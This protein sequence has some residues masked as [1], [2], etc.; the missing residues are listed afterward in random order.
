MTSL[1][2]H[3]DGVAPAPEYA[4]LEEQARAAE[5][6]ETPPWPARAILDVE[7]LT[8]RV[9]DPCCGTGVLTLA[10]RQAGYEVYASDLHDWGF[11][12]ADATGEDFLSWEPAGKGEIVN[13]ATVFMNPPFSRATEFVDQAIRLGARKLLC[14]QR[15]AWRES[16]ER[17]DWWE[18][19]PPARRWICGDRATCW[20]FTV[21][22]EARGGGTP[23]AHC[24]YVWEAGH[25]GAEVG[26][27]VYKHR[28]VSL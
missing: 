15:A 21:P 18:R 13:G 14:F 27:A 7:I 28:R 17:A 2:P 8:R 12:G 20:L 11:A 23:T 19:R 24:W 16:G 5:C 6:W 22:P 9:V 10:A 26:G 1:F 4:T 25:R 3:L